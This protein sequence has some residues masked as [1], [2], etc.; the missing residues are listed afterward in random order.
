MNKYEIGRDFQMLRSRIERLESVFGEHSPD[1]RMRHV[2]ISVPHDRSAGVAQ[3]REPLLW[4]PEKQ[5]LLPPFLHGLLG[6]PERVAKPDLLFDVLP[7]SKTWTC[8]PEP[9]ILYINWDAGGSDEFY[10]FQDQSFSIIRITEPNSGHISC[11]ANYTARLVASGKA[12]TYFYHPPV[13]PYVGDAGF[14]TTSSQFKIIL[15]GAQ[16]SVLGSFTSP[17]YHIECHDN[18]WFIQNW[19]INAGIYDLVTGATW[20]VTGAQSVSRC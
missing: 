16:G 1:A 18:Y 11:T 9:L 19:D 5:M 17:S 8:Q 3:H 10:R 6:V 4:K 20:E 14:Y 2:G 7:E 12:K 13:T 15:R